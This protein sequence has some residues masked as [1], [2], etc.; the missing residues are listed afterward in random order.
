MK[1]IVCSAANGSVLCKN[2]ECAGEWRHAVS[3]QV[4]AVGCYGHEKE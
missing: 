2:G 4:Y 1:F 3:H